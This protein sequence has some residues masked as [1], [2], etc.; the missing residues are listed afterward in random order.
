MN[1]RVKDIILESNPLLEAF[2]NAKTVRNNNS[3]RFVSRMNLEPYVVVLEFHHQNLSCVLFNI[4][5]C[6]S[7]RI[8]CLQ[9]KYVEIQFSRG[10]EPDGGKISNFL[11][12]KVIYKYFL[13]L[14]CTYSVHIFMIDLNSLSPNYN[15]HV[16]TMYINECVANLTIHL[17]K[18]VVHALTS[19]LFYSQG[20]SA[21]IQMNEVF[22]YFTR[23]V[24]V[25][26]RELKVT[27]PCSY[28]ST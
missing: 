24:Q 5:N 2:G 14:P 11:L 26:L 3:S 4:I 10:G 19:I 21:K 16:N 23:Y 8:L 17:P 18:P 13:L 12:E 9:G 7:I 6:F 1:Q 15:G 22:T 25:L 28:W 27:K 20:Q